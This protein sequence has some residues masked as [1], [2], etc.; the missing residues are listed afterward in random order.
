MAFFTVSLARAVTA[1]VS[2]QLE[3]VDV[4]D[5]SSDCMLTPWT[6]WPS[7]RLCWPGRRP[8]KLRNNSNKSPSE[9]PSSDCTLT[10][11]TS[12]PSSRLCWPGRCPRKLRN[13]SNKSPSE[14]PRVSFV[15]FF[16]VFRA[17]AVS[18]GNE[19]SRP[20]SFRP[21]SRRPSCSRANVEA[22][23][24]KRFEQMSLTKQRDE[25]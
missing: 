4:R 19:P 20:L 15:A 11:W 24:R 18:A 17:G 6:S 10:A 22:P 14:S 21:S 7:S 3:Q 16:M 25:N 9:N 1:E 8:R 5:P 13:N 23:S 2:K 12:W